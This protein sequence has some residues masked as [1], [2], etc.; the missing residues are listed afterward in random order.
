MYKQARYITAGLIL[1]ATGL[2][3]LSAQANSAENSKTTKTK[4]ITEL[5]GYDV[6]EV[7]MPASIAKDTQFGKMDTDMDKHISF[8]EFQNASQLDNEYTIFTEIDA[9]SDDKLTYE[10]FYSYNKTKGETKVESTLH[11]K[12]KVKGT[13]LTSRVYMEK[14][15]HVPVDPVVVDVTPIK[16]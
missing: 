4:E 9:N 15:Y 3:A 11:G 5:V 13:N 12:A 8:K 16:K 10:E 7:T 14:N 6:K 1:G 2:I